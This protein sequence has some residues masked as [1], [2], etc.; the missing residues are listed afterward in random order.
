MVGATAV[1]WAAGVAASVEDDS[2]MFHAKRQGFGRKASGRCTVRRMLCGG[3][4]GFTMELEMKVPEE[5]PRESAEQLTAVSTTCGLHDPGVPASA[6]SQELSDIGHAWEGNATDVV[7]Q[8]LWSWSVPL[9]MPAKATSEAAGSNCCSAEEEGLELRVA[10]MSGTELAALRCLPGDLVSEVKRRLARVTGR[11][12][13]EQRLV[14]GSSVLIDRETLAQAGISKPGATLQCVCI[15]PSGVARSLE[16]QRRSEDPGSVLEAALADIVDSVM[17][18][19]HALSERVR[20]RAADVSRAITLQHRGELINWMVQAFDV[21]R[22]DDGIL[23]SVVLTLD[24][25]YARR[26]SPIDVNAIQK[27]L[28][29][30]VCTELKMASECEVPHGHWQR[31]L[32]HLCQGRLS[33]AAILQTEFEVLSKL[34]FVV[35]VPTPVTFLRELSLH[36]RGVPEGMDAERLLQ[37]AL[38][39]LELALFEPDIQYGYPHSILAIGAL[40]AA[41]HT[42]EAPSEQQEAL[43]EDVAVYC[44]EVCQSQDLVLD[45]EEHLLLLWL[46]CSSGTS[47]HAEF[48]LQLETKFG[49]RSRCSVTNLSPRPGLE[50]LRA[51]RAPSSRTPGLVADTW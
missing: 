40:S 15:R 12:A 25:Y 33:V 28:L 8:G 16:A 22:F 14:H 39:L 45:C 7:W 43:L 38:F 32:D 2:A 41:L 44:P 26:V 20:P 35:G 34:G 17:Q 30:A 23:H 11:P 24:R 37:L 9:A 21:L 31:V 42:L 10:S 51:V 4:A 5:A 1:A 29:S 27:V 19:E 3:G 47:S 46:A 36:A 50:Q 48:Y 49:C 6:C 18:A 13:S